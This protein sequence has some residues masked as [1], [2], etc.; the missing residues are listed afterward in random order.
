MHFVT[1]SFLLLVV[2]LGTSSSV[3]VTG[4][5]GCSCNLV[6]F[7]VGGAGCVLGSSAEFGLARQTCARAVEVLR[8]RRRLDYP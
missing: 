5:N 2:L 7:C 1:S 6:E 4:C 8:I 3:L